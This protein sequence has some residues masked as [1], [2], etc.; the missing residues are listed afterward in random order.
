MNKETEKECDFAVRARVFTHPLCLS[1][2]VSTIKYLH[3]RKIAISDT[4]LIL[5]IIIIII[6]YINNISI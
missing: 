1:K 2:N 5:I 4:L 6:I 3:W